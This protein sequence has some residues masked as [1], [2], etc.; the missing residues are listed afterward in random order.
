MADMPRKP[1]LPV[2]CRSVCLAHRR[3]LVDGL[4][5]RHR[6]RDRLGE[7]GTRRNT[8]RSVVAAEDVTIDGVRL[9][10]GDAGEFEHPGRSTGRSA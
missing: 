6:V 4:G 1:K 10:P 8:M 3:R 5:D 9:N 2:I 7:K